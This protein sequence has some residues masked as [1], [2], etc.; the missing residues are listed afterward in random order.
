MTAK[1]SGASVKKTIIG[2]LVCVAAVVLVVLIGITVS[3]ALSEK[4]RPVVYMKDSSVLVY[5]GKE[6]FVVR[7]VDDSDAYVGIVCAKKQPERFVFANAAATEGAAAKGLSYTDGKTDYISLTND[8]AAL[9]GINEQGTRVFWQNSLGALYWHD[10]STSRKLSDFVSN[11]AFNDDMSGCVFVERDGTAYYQKLDEKEA[12]KV[13]IAERISNIEYYK[14]DDVFFTL[15]G[16]ADTSELVYYNTK[17]GKSQSYDDCALSFYY[18]D[19]QGFYFFLNTAEPSA[20]VIDLKADEDAKWAVKNGEITEYG[21][22]T[23]NW[24]YWYD[25][26][27]SKNTSEVKGDLSSMT[28]EAYHEYSARVAVRDMLSEISKKMLMEA[29]YFDGS[30]AQRA[31]SEVIAV[32]SASSIY[33]DA[34]PILLSI[35]NGTRAVFDVQTLATQLIGDVKAAQFVEADDTIR[36]DVTFLA[37]DPARARYD[38][39]A[40]LSGY[41]NKSMN[42]AIMEKGSVRDTHVGAS[43]LAS[44]SATPFFVLNISANASDFFMTA[45]EYASDASTLYT[46]PAR[47]GAVPNKLSESAYASISTRWGYIYM[48]GSHSDYTVSLHSSSGASDSGVAPETV[49]ADKT[50]DSVYYLKDFNGHDGE[51]WMLSGSK[52]KKICDGVY[53]YVPLNSGRIMVMRNFNEVTRT[54]ELYVYGKDG[55]GECVDTGVSKILSEMN[56]EEYYIFA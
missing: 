31:A 18:P 41:V 45:A 49:C 42:Y 32:E 38:A 36:T 48:D 27:I 44:D 35:T 1:S 46:K 28:L 54:G 11:F 13:K 24:Y 33:N 8:D 9:Y 47:A 26:N 19:S 25:F 14:T 4:D 3:R 10:L 37:E 53:Y 51:L 7:K 52:T 39:Y 17:S 30:K 21:Y 6:S 12:E 22:P 2:A 5:D 50:S 16:S 34:S 23:G 15:A 43:E 56:A 20:K 40:A 29:W 55:K